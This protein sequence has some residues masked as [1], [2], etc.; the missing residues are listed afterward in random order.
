MADFK[1]FPVPGYEHVTS[2]T[3]GDISV[4]LANHLLSQLASSNGDNEED[5]YHI[6]YPWT[7]KM[8]GTCAHV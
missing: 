5:H 4:L 1:K 3:D 8:K 6:L 7:P 2:L